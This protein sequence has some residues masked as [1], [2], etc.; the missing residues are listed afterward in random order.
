MIPFAFFSFANMGGWEWLIILVIVLIFFGAGKLPSVFR[1]FGQATKAF[2]DAQ[3]GDDQVDVSPSML[4]EKK[5]ADAQ[6]VREKE[7]A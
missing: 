3:K 1:Q 7:T 2:R 6:E 5:V 4:D